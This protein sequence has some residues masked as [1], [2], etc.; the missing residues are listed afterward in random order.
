MAAR[1][2]V[3]PAAYITSAHGHLDKNVSFLQ[4]RN[5]FLSKEIT[6]WPF[7]FSLGVFN[8]NDRRELSPYR[9]RLLLLTILGEIWAFKTCGS[10]YHTWFGIH[11]QGHLGEC[12]THTHTHTAA[13]KK[14]KMNI[15]WILEQSVFKPC[16]VFFFVLC[17]YH[18]S[19]FQPVSEIKNTKNIFLSRVRPSKS[20]DSFSHYNKL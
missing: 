18:S 15:D 14:R 11:G 2:C 8:Q 16:C 19:H 4:A 20:I 13:G 5:F 9:A 3:C 17:R 12:G 6:Q 1:I 10:L 7:S